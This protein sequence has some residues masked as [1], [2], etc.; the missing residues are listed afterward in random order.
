MHVEVREKSGVVIVD[1]KGKL[2]AGLGDQ[3]LRESIDE[4][5]AEGRKKIL[6]NL[7][8]VSFVDSAGVGELVAGLRTAAA[9]RAALKLLNVT[10]RVYGT[11]YMARL[12]PIFEIY[13]DEAEAVATFGTGT[14]L[15]Q[16]CTDRR[17]YRPRPRWAVDV[18]DRL[19]AVH[20]SSVA[21]GAS[22]VASSWSPR[23]PS[24]ASPA[25]TARRSAGARRDSLSSAR[26][27]ADSSMFSRQSGSSARASEVGLDI[28]GSGQGWRPR[29]SAP[30]APSRLRAP[31]REGRPPS[32]RW[33]RESLRPGALAVDQNVDRTIG[34]PGPRSSRRPHL[35]VAGLGARGL[36]DRASQRSGVAESDERERRS[37]HAVGLAVLAATSSVR[38]AA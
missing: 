9:F 14:I 30:G 8:D 12:L 29:G 24:R 4:L 32:R 27:L 18:G 20:G 16:T 15:T 5:L 17:G 37:H 26:R 25:Q 38:I 3:I 23:D 6:L 19:G 7:S 1:L 11:L 35:P 28:S 2:T 13:G 36:P 33:A 21:L 22:L 10:E 31:L 34:C